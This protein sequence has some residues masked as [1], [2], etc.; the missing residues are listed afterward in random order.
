MNYCIF[1]TLIFSPIAIVLALQ[2]ILFRLWKTTSAQLITIL[3][4]LLGIPFYAT[5]YCSL[6]RNSAHDISGIAYYAAIYSFSTYT[7]FHFFNMSETSRRVRLV[8]FINP[9]QGSEKNALE[10]IFNEKDMIQVRLDRMVALG[11]L[12]KTGDKYSSAGY[13][14]YFAAAFLKCLATALNRKWQD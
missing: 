3:S 9:L 5:L 14:F 11:Q 13:L 7:Y 12:K 6:S 4:M 10:N 1:F 2:S 8:Q